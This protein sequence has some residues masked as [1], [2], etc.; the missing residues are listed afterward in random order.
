MRLDIKKSETL[1][2]T[3][4]MRTQFTD[5]SQFASGLVLNNYNSLFSGSPELQSALS[6]NINLS[7]YSFNMFNYTN[8]FANINYNKSIDNIRTVSVFNPGSVI[9]VST[10][11]NSNF[12]DESLTASGRYQRTFGKL[13]GFCKS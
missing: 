9:R 3:Y 6:H 13:R 1:N 12:A 11:F 5:V 10:P 7:Y 8:V 4:R 2:L